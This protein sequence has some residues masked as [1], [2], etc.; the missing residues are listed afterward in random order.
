V[1]PRDPWQPLPADWRELLAARWP[2]G[3][4]LVIAWRLATDVDTL[5]DLLAGL[6][7]SPDRLDSEALFQ[8][9]R[10][11]LVQLRAPVELV[12]VVEDAA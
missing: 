12:N 9:R 8:A 3:E 1:I 10:R 7:V 2:D 4:R 11:S 6:P 5:G